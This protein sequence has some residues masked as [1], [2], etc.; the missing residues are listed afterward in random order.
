LDDILGQNHFFKN[1]FLNGFNIL[2]VDAYSGVEACTPIFLGEASK[3]NSSDSKSFS[4]K[5]LKLNWTHRLTKLNTNMS[6]YV[7]NI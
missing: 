1:F 3:K 5:K 4:K 6:C 2:V 7:D